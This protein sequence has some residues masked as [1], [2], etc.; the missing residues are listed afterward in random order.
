M[1]ETEENKAHFPCKIKRAHVHRWGRRLGRKAVSITKVSKCTKKNPKTPGAN[2]EQR[3][4]RGLCIL[5]KKATKNPEVLKRKK[6]SAS[7]TIPL[8]LS[9]HCPGKDTQKNC[10]LSTSCGAVCI[11]DTSA[12]TLQSWKS[13]VWVWNSYPQLVVILK[14]GHLVF[15]KSNL[16][17]NVFFTL[18]L[19]KFLKDL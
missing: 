5:K 4:F 18:L 15:I 12:F 2:P 13:E 8:C 10:L 19:P 6:G 9:D 11:S 16:E 3:W 14:C 7:D 17:E 1:E